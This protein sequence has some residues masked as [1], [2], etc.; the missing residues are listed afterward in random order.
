MQKAISQLIIEIQ[1]FL[2]ANMLTLENASLNNC[3]SVGLI[4]SPFPFFQPYEGCWSTSSMN[5][6]LTMYGKITCQESPDR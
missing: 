4:N 1:F 2:V 6:I 3:L 5:A